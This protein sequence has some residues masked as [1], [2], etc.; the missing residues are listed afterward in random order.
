MTAIERQALEALR[1]PPTFSL[2]IDEDLEDFNFGDVLDGTDTL[3][4]SNAG[5]EFGDLARG[6][7]GKLPT[8]QLLVSDHYLSHNFVDQFAW[9]SLHTTG[10]NTKKAWGIYDETGI[11]VAVCRHGFCLLITDMVQ[12]GELAKYPLAIVAKLL[13]AFGGGLGGGY[14]IGCQ[15]RTTPDNSSLGPLVCSLCHTCLVGAFHGHVHKRLCQLF[16]LTTYIKGL[17]IEDLET[18]ER[19]FS[20]SN[21]LASAL[22]YTSVFHHQQAIDSY[23][24]HNNEFE[25]Y[26]NLSNF[27]HG[28][29]KQALKILENSKFVLPKVMQ[30]LRIKDESIFERW[31]EDEKAYLKDLMQEPE[32]ETIQMEYWQRLVNLSASSVAL[33]VAMNSFTPSQHNTLPYSA[34]LA[35]TRKA[36]TTHCHALEDY[37]RNLRA[38]QTHSATIRSTLN[39]YNKLA[40]AVYPPWQILKWEE[41]VDAMDLYFK[42]C[43]AHEEICHLNVKV[44]CLVTYIHDEDKYL[45]VSI[46]TPWP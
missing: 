7:L 40:S 25:V 15:F 2:N 31:L 36:K 8:G 1:D 35:N 23:F 17:G 28:N 27:L 34:D 29:Y 11:F 30:D 6:V 13:D 3:P 26:G 19:T 21:A 37:E 5:G 44:C 18:C 45:R 41:V 42:M 43:R 32:E 16:S 22:Q 38:L 46:H 20:K 33:D 14:D 24:E 12:S 9:D 39:T 4:I 10:D